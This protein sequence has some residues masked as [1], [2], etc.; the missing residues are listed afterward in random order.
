MAG[1]F[2]F[3]HRGGQLA[4][5]FEIPQWE[6]NLMIEVSSHVCVMH[7]SFPRVFVEHFRNTL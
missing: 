5:E 6:S 2:F 7:G 1:L 3:P 4:P